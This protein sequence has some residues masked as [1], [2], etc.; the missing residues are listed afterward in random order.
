[1]KMQMK[2]IVFGVFSLSVACRNLVNLPFLLSCEGERG[3]RAQREEQEGDR[4]GERE[5]GKK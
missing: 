4:E 3:M 1:M 2:T 5:G